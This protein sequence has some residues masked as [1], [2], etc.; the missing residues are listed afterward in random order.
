MEERRELDLE[1][2]LVDLYYYIKKHIVL[3][4][5]VALLGG[6]LGY[7]HSRM[8]ETPVYRATTTV[9]LLS[10]TSEVDVVYTDFQI[11]NQLV[12]DFRLLVK[13]RS[14][15][16]AV[17]DELDLLM[18]PETLISKVTVE[19][20][21]DSRVVYIKVEDADAKRAASIANSLSRIGAQTIQGIMALDAVTVV[22]EAVVPTAP[23]AVDHNKAGMMGALIA[24]LVLI[25]TLLVIRTMD[26]SIRSEE[27]VAHYLG[28]STLGVIPDAKS[29]EDWLKQE[30]KNVKRRK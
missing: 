29:T 14:V 26:D 19:S 2:D 5:I 21:T 17:I 10:R 20:V 27:D 15:A 30:K 3:I 11:S 6:V 7:N 12:K 16:A 22:E 9:Y 1:L 23:V 13:G 18:S 25:L 28:I 4:L 8:T 24:A